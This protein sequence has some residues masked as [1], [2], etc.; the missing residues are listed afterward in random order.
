[1]NKTLGI[2]AI[3][4]AGLA[5]GGWLMQQRGNEAAAPGTTQLAPM[6][7]GAQAQTAAAAGLRGADSK[8]D[9]WVVMRTFH[10][11]RRRSSSRD[12]LAAVRRAAWR[13]ACQAPRT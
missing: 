6:T 3:A 8:V 10:S 13:C 1:M 9:P 5:A 2:A 12:L 4:A 7:G 11:C